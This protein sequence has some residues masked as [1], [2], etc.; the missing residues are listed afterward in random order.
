MKLN[1]LVGLLM[2]A[3]V[4]TSMALACGPAA[5]PTSEPSPAPTSVPE[6]E[7]TPIPPTATPEAK[8]GELVFGLSWEPS[9]LDPHVTSSNEGRYV[10]RYVFDGLVWQSPDGTIYPVLA[11]EWRVS[12]DG[13]TYTF[14]L[15]Q[16]VK[17]HDGTRF[18]AE[19]VKY[20]LD[21]IVDPATKSEIAA[22]LLGPYESTEVLDEY[23]VAV[24]LS[25]PYSALLTSLSIPYLAMVSPEAA[26]QWGEEF[27]DHLVGTGPF[28]F[29]EW[30]HGDHLTLVKNP[31]YNWAP[32]FY[33]HE[34]P[35]YLEQ[36]TFKFI[37][38]AT[39]RV[40]TLETGETHMINDVPPDS[41]DLLASDSQYATLQAV[42]VGVPCGVGL[43]V[44][45][46]PFD[47]PKV[48]QAI[49][50][51]ID[52]ESIADTLFLGLWPA[53]Y[54]PVSPPTVGYWEGAKDMYVYD[55]EM[56]KSLLEEAGWVD[57][58]GDGIREKDGEPFEVWWPTFK[59]ERMN[60]MAEM[61]QAQLR[62]IGIDV[63]VEVTTFPAMFEAAT[64]C[65]HNMVHVGFALPDPEIALSTVFESSNV[66]TGWAHTC[67]KDDE[68]DE[69]L[70]Q[71]RATIDFDERIPIY[72]ELQEVIMEKAYMV[73][74][75]EWTSLLATRGEVKD[76]S[77]D[78]DGMVP[79][80]YDAYVE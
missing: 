5:T 34:G 75:R 12:E 46:P 71:T 4:L 77:I 23:K 54:A 52:N 53:A 13:L 9:A 66:G 74:V 2:V 47:D 15:R 25:A 62:E 44:T 69:L 72:T 24:H 48:R 21:R 40:G 50:Y 39:V 67:A 11:T 8:G 31:D 65:D 3:V 70:A 73:P 63:V 19:A 68:I 29:E 59:F 18:N 1:R 33:G 64:N 80:L 10:A 26:E 60:E 22:S 61:V 41:Y 43:N 49:E 7:A 57:E 38:E 51:A 20:S 35:A 27:D 14:D 42:K 28:I 16:D 37:P 17:F 30:E 55:Q 76:V 45:K 79:L 6:V 58:D 56:A 78:F 32:T 36:L